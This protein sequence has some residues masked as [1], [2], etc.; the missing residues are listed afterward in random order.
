MN[1]FS[2]TNIS[3]G[4][5]FAFKLL[6]SAYNSFNGVNI[7]GARFFV[8]L[9]AVGLFYMGMIP[10]AEYFT[11]QKTITIWGSTGLLNSINRDERCV[12]FYL[13]YSLF[14]LIAGVLVILTF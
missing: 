12:V 9:I 7:T 3:L 1:P 13:A 14:A 4:C 2:M 10:F 6:V 5:L 8:L 11:G